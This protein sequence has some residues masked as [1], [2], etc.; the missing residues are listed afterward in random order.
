ML[1]LGT[2]EAM[3]LKGTKTMTEILH[4]WTDVVFFSKYY[5]YFFID[6]TYL[7]LSL[8]CWARVDCLFKNSKLNF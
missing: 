1:I 7:I 5:K 6:N 8:E 4:V 3:F 2:F